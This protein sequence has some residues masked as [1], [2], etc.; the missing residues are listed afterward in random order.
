M[1]TTSV[2]SL[3]TIA[4][5][6]LAGCEVTDNSSLQSVS[7]YSVASEGT[8]VPLGQSVRLH[9]ATITPLEVIED[10]RCPSDVQCAYEGRLRLRVEV[11]NA[12]KTETDVIE[13]AEHASYYGLGYILADVT[14]W[15]RT[16]NEMRDENYRFRFARD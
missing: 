16:T 2:L 8:Y 6:A 3:C 4:A 11:T 12:A 9:T 7:G 13:F 14:P 5:L 1:K 15:P 10:S